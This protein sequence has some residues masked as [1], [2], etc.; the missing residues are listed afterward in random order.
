[1]KNTF[2]KR[3]E[4]LTIETDEVEYEGRNITYAVINSDLSP[5]PRYF[6]GYGNGNPFISEEVPESYR[7]P[8]IIHEVVEFEKF[9]GIEGRCLEALN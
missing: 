2:K 3:L 9:N 6:V 8:M 4:E 1:M 5:S 7:I